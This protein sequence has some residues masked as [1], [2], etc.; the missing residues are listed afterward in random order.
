MNI[1][2]LQTVRPRRLVDAYDFRKLRTYR[3][4]TC[5]GSDEMSGNVPSMSVKTLDNACDFSLA[6]GSI[7]ARKLGYR[8]P[9]SSCV[10][11]PCKA[12]SR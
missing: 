7:R 4:A 6:R 2:Y 11:T 10:G 5:S 1:M 3:I 12:R 9:M 8:G